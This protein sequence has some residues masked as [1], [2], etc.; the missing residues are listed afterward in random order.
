MTDFN[1][2]DHA[3]MSRA[4][5]LA[6]NG[7]Y[8]AH[9]NPRVGCVIARDGRIVGEGFHRKAGEAHAEVNALNQAGERARG[10]TVYVTLEPCNHSG[11]TGPCSAA[12]IAAGVAEVVYAIADP[13]TTASGGIQALKDAGVGVRG[14][15]L[16]DQAAKL[17]EGFIKRCRMGVPFVTL[18]LAMSLDGRTAMAS[19][20]SQWITGE[21]ARRDVQKLRAQSG[22]IVTGIGS[23]LLD[24]PAMTVRQDMLPVDNA[25]EVA[26]RQPLR[27]VVDS[28]LRTPGDAKMLHQP[29]SVLIA[30]TAV[31]ARAQD[32][33]PANVEVM[34][35][36]GADG[37]VELSALLAHLGAAEC[38]DVLVE[39]GAELGGAFVR[40]GLVDRLVIYMAAKLMGSRARPLLALPF[41]TLA[42]AVDLEIEDVRPLGSD[43]RITVVPETTAQA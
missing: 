13:H 22:A 5:Q 15:L 9:P 21:Q 33:Y 2:F 18:K 23:V 11:R 32:R 12:L 41:D 4:L 39:A 1:G 34:G 25:A 37:R 7:W 16:Q 28:R 20:E 29:G 36:P 38:N 6:K 35:F 26:A 31:A 24:N 19:G 42:E 43:W 14:P 40:A 30:T 8:S 10:S 17:N 3:C 27:V